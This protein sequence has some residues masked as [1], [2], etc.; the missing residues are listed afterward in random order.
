MDAQKV[1]GVPPLREGINP[2]TW[3]L[4]VSTL[5]KEDELGVDFAD[6]ST[7]TVTSTGMVSPCACSLRRWALQLLYLPG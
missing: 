5:S 2:A 7:A 6:Y 1:K 4:E 3:M